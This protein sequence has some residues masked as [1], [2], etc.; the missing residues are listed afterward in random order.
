MNR[1]SAKR[2][3]AM[4]ALTAALIATDHKTINT[5]ENAPTQTRW[6]NNISR[7]GAAYTVIPVAAGFFFTGAAADDSKARETGVLG[8][9]ALLDGLIVQEV[10]KPIAG[11]DRPYMAH[12]H[13][14]WFDGGSSFPSGHAIAAW[15]MASVISRQYPHHKWVPILTYG[16]AA[17]VGAARFSAQQHYLS[18]VVVGGAIGWFIGHYVVG[19]HS[20][21][22]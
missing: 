7:V 2:W 4:G 1:S 11:R 10:L 9:E 19:A 5:F 21:T 14:K 17:T 16:L 22:Q 20:K 3:V 18:D 8:A 12:D 6:G 15:S 13:P